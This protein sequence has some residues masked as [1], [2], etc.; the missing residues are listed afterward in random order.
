MGKLKVFQTTNQESLVESVGLVEFRG[1]VLAGLVYHL[2]PSIIFYH[3][4]SLKKVY[5]FKPL[6]FHQ[7]MGMW[8]NH[9]LPR[10]IP[11][12][13]MEI[14]PNDLR[15]YIYISSRPSFLVIF[16]VIFVGFPYII[17]YGS[18]LSTPNSWMVLSY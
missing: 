15:R 10:S 4:L 8:D 2:Y 7:P 16:L 1:D 11:S 9:L 12:A 5:T 14:P 13:S 6:Y 17:G 3:C 18:K